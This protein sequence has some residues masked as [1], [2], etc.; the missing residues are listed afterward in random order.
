MLPRIFPPFPDRKEFNIYATMEPAKEVGGDF[1]DFFFIGKN[2][3][4]FLIADVSGKGVP[5]ALFMV[6]SKTLLKTAAMQNLQPDEIFRR[7]N[8]LLFPDNDEC[9]FVTV[10]CAIL[11]THKGE[12]EY[13]SAGHN[14]PLIYTGG[15]KFEYLKIGNSFVLGAMEDMTYKSEKLILKPNDIFF[16]YTDGITEAINPNEELFGDERLQ[17]TISK[18]KDEKL[19]EMLKGIR[20]EIKN[21]EQGA[22][23]FDDITMLALKYKG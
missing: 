17:K 12:L 1:Y 9:M 15:E 3:L 21:F 20:E 6:I 14:P 19:P 18:L 4:C 8:D 7:V 16:M 22:P 11:D 13:A 2:K 23:Q 5:A 10:F